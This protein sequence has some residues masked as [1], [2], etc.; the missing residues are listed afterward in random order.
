MSREKSERDK[1]RYQLLFLLVI[2]LMFILT[3]MFIVA[4]TLMGFG[5]DLSFIGF[6]NK[7]N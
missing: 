3:V 2:G 6:E 1:A 7:T 4:D 5:I